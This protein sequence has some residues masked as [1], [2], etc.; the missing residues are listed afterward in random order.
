MLVIATC[1]ATSDATTNATT[2]ATTNTTTDA[3]T[4]ATTDATATAPLDDLSLLGALAESLLEGDSSWQLSV[5]A[6][7]VVVDEEHLGLSGV[8]G[9]LDDLLVLGA[10]PLGEHV[11][12]GLLLR[13]GSHDGLR[14]TKAVGSSYEDEV[15]VNLAG[16]ET[17]RVHCSRCLCWC[18]EQEEV[19][20][21]LWSSTTATSRATSTD[22]T[23]ANR[24]AK[25]ATAN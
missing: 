6:F 24:P 5:V 14:A 8:V 22:S 23:T 15:V 11:D 21:D 18:G 13:S 10:R 9:N 3:T 7:V 17:G 2:D 20:G 19:P 12:Q 25:G 4:N 1:S 16:R